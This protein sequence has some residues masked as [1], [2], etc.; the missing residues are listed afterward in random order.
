MPTVHYV[1]HSFLKQN[2]LHIECENTPEGTG[3]SIASQDETKSAATSNTQRH[4]NHH[5]ASGS[6]KRL[7]QN[8]QNFKIKIRRRDTSVTN[9]SC[10]VAASNISDL[11]RKNG[12][13]VIWVRVGNTDHAAYILRNPDGTDTANDMIWVEWASNMDKERV[14]KHQIVKDGLQARK[15]RRPNY[16]S[17]QLK[18]PEEHV[19]NRQPPHNTKHGG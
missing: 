9:K 7:Q 18:T 3:K 17:H 12:E 4:S 5:R 13:E 14:F 6:S 15:R 10:A 1:K 11:K 2:G 19:D 16:F 8:Q